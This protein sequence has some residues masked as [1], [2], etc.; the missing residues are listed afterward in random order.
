MDK[1]YIPGMNCEV[2]IRFCRLGSRIV[3][4]GIR[5]M[6]YLYRNDDIVG[7]NLQQCPLT[8]VTAVFGC[9]AQLGIN[10]TLHDATV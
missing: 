8:K 7:W 10:M 1:N 5:C 9:T 2:T 4:L 3:A 6:P